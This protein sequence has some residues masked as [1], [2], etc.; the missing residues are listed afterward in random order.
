MK[1]IM[2]NPNSPYNDTQKLLKAINRAYP[3]RYTYEQIAVKAGLSEKSKSRVSN[4]ASG[5]AKATYA[6]LQYFIDKYEHLINRGQRHLLISNPIDDDEST[7]TYS[8]LI[9]DLVLNHSSYKYEASG[10]HT[11][12]VAIKRI[13]IIKN[14]D[15]F[16]LVLQDRA[17]SKIQH[18]GTIYIHSE[19]EN[20]IWWSRF[21]EIT[22]PDLIDWVDN[23]V[24]EFYDQ[25]DDRNSF[26]SDL[27]TLPFVIREM[28]IKQGYPLN[29]VISIIE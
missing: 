16:W 20:A 11:K 18:T 24:Q 1:R 21:E 28:L 5:K 13:R 23:R 22:P 12:R 8:M 17:T 19:N 27:L 3:K 15:R 14:G 29:D 10:R 4:W 7:S 25:C 9:G 6:Q 26:A 2:N